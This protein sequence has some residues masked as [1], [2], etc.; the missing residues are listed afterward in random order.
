MENIT[1]KEQCFVEAHELIDG[2]VITS[3]ELKDLDYAADNNLKIIRCNYCDSPATHIDNLYP[4]YQQANY[5]D[6]HSDAMQETI[7]VDWN[8]IKDACQDHSL[9]ICYH[10]STPIALK[11]NPPKI[12]TRCCRENCPIWKG[13]KK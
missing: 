8:M 11:I 10:N 13:I 4:Y 2:H 6:K 12:K 1:K 7:V 9:D 3:Y 5:C